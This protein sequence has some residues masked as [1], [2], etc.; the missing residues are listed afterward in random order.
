MHLLTK[1]MQATSL[2][3]CRECGQTLSI[4]ASVCPGCG[5]RTPFCCTV[6][7]KPLS[8]VTLGVAPT[9][10]H[11]Y[12][13][14]T[15]EGDPVCHAH[16]LTRCHDCESLFPQE[17]MSRHVVGQHADR[18]LREGK[19]PRIEPVF[20]YFCQACDSPASLS[21]PQAQKP[22]LIGLL[23]LLGGLALGLITLLPTR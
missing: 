6:C 20:G 18:Q 7:A 9:I 8:A 23:I 22:W 3:P 14:F 10:K 12:G 16:R 15:V 1:T 4:D 19:T 13:S 21:L 11:P 17:A 5:S 2:L